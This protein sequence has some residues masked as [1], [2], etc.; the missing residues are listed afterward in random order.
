MKVMSH[1]PPVPVGIGAAGTYDYTG[2]VEGDS[3]H[4]TDDRSRT[5]GQSD[6]SPCISGFLWGLVF[7]LPL[8]LLLS[9]GVWFA[10]SAV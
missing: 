1:A 8:W 6:V 5:C 7:S 9:A 3:V 2:A 4:R 10:A